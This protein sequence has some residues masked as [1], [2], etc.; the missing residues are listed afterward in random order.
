MA[1]AD[2]YP[3]CYGSWQMQ[4]LVAVS[5]RDGWQCWRNSACTCVLASNSAE[6][7]PVNAQNQLRAT[8]ELTG[9]PV[10]YNSAHIF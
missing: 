6:R 10:A 8:S 4:Q 9:P 7:K 3:L 2:D 5:V 1:H